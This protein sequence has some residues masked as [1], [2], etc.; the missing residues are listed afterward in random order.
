[1][2]KTTIERYIDAVIDSM[3]HTVKFVRDG[4]VNATRATRKERIDFALKSIERDR[5]QAFGALTYAKTFE[6]TMTDD[7]DHRL[8]WKVLEAEKE[9]EELAWKVIK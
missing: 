5:E 8:T 3:R 1:M 2:K 7:L 9:C 4:G 6:G